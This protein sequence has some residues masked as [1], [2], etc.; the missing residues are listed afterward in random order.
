MADVTT[1]LP[2]LSGALFVAF[3]S[4]AAL[5]GGACAQGETTPTESGGGGDAS[6]TTST[7][8]QGTGA[9]GGQG[10]GTGGEG[11]GSTDPC[12]IDCSSI[13][14]PDCK[15]AVCNEG[16]YMGTVGECVV[17]D[18]DDGTECDDGMFCTVNDACVA[19][20]CTGGGDNHCGIVPEACELVTCDEASASCTTAPVTDGDPCTS[21]NLCEVNSTC[22]NG[23]CE[24][25]IK[26]C[27]FAP[28]PDECHVAV[29][30]PS[31]GMCE[32]VQGNDGQPCIDPNDLCTDN[33]I[34]DS[35][36][37]VG[38]GPKDCSSADQECAVGVCDSATGNC[39][40]DPVMPGT[41]CPGATDECNDGFCDA[42]GVCQP[43]PTPGVSCPSATDECNAGVCDAA[44][45]CQAN[46]TAGVSCASATDD[47]NAGVCDAG[48]VCQANTSNEGG[49][50]DDGLTCTTGTTC[51]AGICGGG[52]S[53]INIFFSEDFSSNAAGWTLDNEWQIG[54]AVSSPSPG[55]C[56]SGDPG[57]DTSSS[58]DNGIAGV[59]IGGNASTA[60][61][62]TYYI[63]SPPIDTSA[64]T[65]SLFLS[66]QRWLNSDYTRY[67]QNFVEV[68]D[69]STWTVVWQTGGSPGV[70]DSAWTPMSHDITAYK[71]ANMQV[72][73]GF[74]VGSA[75]VFTCSGWNLDDVLIA[76]G[77]CN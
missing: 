24:G 10:G 2:R 23:V 6:T 13:D 5:S 58:A 28:V 73:F 61:H 12:D 49:A 32:A 56:G 18:A 64:V 76:D 75:G 52:T 63:T 50:C 21:P 8:G 42:A 71:A 20:V 39:V 35:G 44:G 27:F 22:V 29:C 46:P 3:A 72:R 37:C 51:T 4:C 30:N 69:G 14:T 15:V 59:V 36:T 31:N 7:G 53:T 25:Q 40:P 67:M 38:G 11:A 65:G 26:D 9:S 60:Q 77:T 43:T 74:L 41:A 55:A 48:G 1:P 47:C 45:V 17:V 62:A 33:K 66:Y 70:E 34:C 54:P 16:Q 68:Y 57:T 19:G